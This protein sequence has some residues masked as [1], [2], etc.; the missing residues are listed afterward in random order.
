MPGSAPPEPGRPGRR[1]PSGPA[2]GPPTSR[3]SVRTATSRCA[4]SRSA[5]SSSARSSAASSRAPAGRR[6]R[7]LSCTSSDRSAPTSRSC[8]S[9]TASGSTSAATSSPRGRLLH[10]AVHRSRGAR[11]PDHLP[12]VR[13]PAGGHH[14]RRRAGV[15]QRGAGRVRQHLPDVRRRRGHARPRQ[16]RARLRAPRALHPA[17]G[18]P[19]RRSSIV[20]L[21][22]GRPARRVL[23]RVVGARALPADRQPAAQGAGRRLPQKTPTACRGPPRSARPSASPKS[24]SRR[25]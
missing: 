2:C 19:R 20:A 11:L 4:G 25:S 5:W 7:R 10:H 18:S 13:A 14:A 15:V 9:S 3:C 8:R 21:Q 23:R 1:R 16:G 22:R 24:S 6:R 17:E 12:R